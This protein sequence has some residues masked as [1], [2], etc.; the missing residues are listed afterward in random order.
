M[1]EKH[2]DADQN[3]TRK[4]RTDIDFT[5]TGDGT[6]W[7]TG[8]TSSITRGSQVETDLRE[9]DAEAPGVTG[10]KPNRDRE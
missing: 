6:A 3:D 5:T 9:G 1:A 4:D 2:R 10:P 7:D 8:R